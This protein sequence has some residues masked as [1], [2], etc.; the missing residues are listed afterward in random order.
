MNSFP[1]RQIHLDFHTS[2]DIPGIGENFDAERFAATLKDAGVASINLFAKCH[3]GWFYTPVETGKMHPHLQFDLLSQQIEAC[4]EAGIRSNIYFTIGFSEVDADAHPEWQMVDRDGNSKMGQI[5]GAVQA[6]GNPMINKVAAQQYFGSIAYWRY[7]CVNHVEYVDLIKAQ[8][9]EI[10]ERFNPPGLWLDI[11]LQSLCV[12]DT[13]RKEMSEMGLDPENDGHIAVHGRMVEI[14]FFKEITSYI[15]GI[16]PGTDVYINGFGQKMDLQDQPDL[17]SARKVESVSLF[18][19]ESLP[20]MLWEYVHFPIN[21]QYFN[22][23]SNTKPLTMMSGKFHRVW[24]DFGSLKNVEAM[25]YEA[26]RALTYGC[27]VCIGDQLLPDGHLEP[28]VYQ[29]IKT[30][31][32]RVKQCETLVEGATKQAEI[33]VFLDNSP[34]AGPGPAMEGAYRIL[35]EMHYQFDFIDFTDELDVSRYKLLVLPDRVRLPE[36]MGEKLQQYLD[37]GESYY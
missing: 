1:F 15:Q 12:C 11:I 24:G 19:I 6:R 26:F 21:A 16:A 18:D 25:E 20:S 5:M 27:R 23:P 13:C 28:T 31:F 3:H 37:E 7:L 14:R 4:K 35:T 17:S 33:G 8:L 22:K 32:N 34:P 9:K 29:Q 2:P 36:A 10:L 30:V